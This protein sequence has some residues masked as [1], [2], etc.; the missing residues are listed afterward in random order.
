MPIDTIGMSD[1]ID[2]GV[3]HHF[4]DGLYAKRMN[5]ATGSVAVTHSHRY[6]HLSILA[7]GRVVL[8]TNGTQTE[9]VAP[10][11]INI[12]AGVHHQ[13][14][15][16]EPSIWFCIHATDEADPEKIDEI[17]LRK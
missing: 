2:L 10:A 13:I 1:E 7:T 12:C 14:E 17:I 16:L 9:Y 4:S 6:D 15:S 11:C 8:T 5:L 3:V